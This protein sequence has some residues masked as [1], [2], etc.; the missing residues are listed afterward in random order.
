MGEIVGGAGG[1]T[2]SVNEIENNWLSHIRKGFNRSEQDQLVSASA[3]C[4]DGDKD[5]CQKV[6]KLVVLSKQR[7]QIVDAACS[8]GPSADCTSAV[9]AAVKEGNKVIFGADGLANFYPLNTPELKPT[10][11]IGVGSFD[12]TVSKS[13]SEGLLLDIGG[14]G[15]GAVLSGLG[16]LGSLFGFGAAKG[17]AEVA[18]TGKALNVA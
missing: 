4:R 6:D 5:A 12:Q 9:S 7:D 15:S 1:A 11:Q 17:T 16:R 13:T 10:P 3:A 18:S 8:A 14:I 2:A